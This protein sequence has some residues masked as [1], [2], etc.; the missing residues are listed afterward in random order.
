M[1]LVLQYNSEISVTYAWGIGCTEE[2]PASL[3][4]V[5]DRIT[6]LLPNSVIL[7]VLPT[8]GEIR[9]TELWGAPTV[10]SS[11]WLGI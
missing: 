3:I 9:R 5:A 7:R 10:E 2:D 11:G 4:S 8:D 1:T 6:V